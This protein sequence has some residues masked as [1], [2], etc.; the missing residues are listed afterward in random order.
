[1]SVSLY[2]LLLLIFRAI[3]IY[4]IIDVIRK[5]KQLRKRVLKD[6]DVIILRRD[7]YILSI[8]VL[9]INII[10]VVVDISTLFGYTTRPDNVN[11]LSVLYVLSYSIGTLLLTLIL[12][13]MYR[14]SLKQ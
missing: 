7:M 12:W 2:A 3:S 8:A 11:I 6:K 10:P 4:L 9:C 1:M 14:N 13:R 5:Q